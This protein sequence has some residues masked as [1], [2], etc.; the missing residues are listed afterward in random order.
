MKM[1]ALRK[2]AQFRNVYKF[3]IGWRN[4]LVIVKAVANDL[5]FSRYGFSVTKS[6]GKAVVRNKI[7]RR[8]REIM[9]M[10]PV[11]SGW[12][13]VVI[14]RPESVDTD[15][16]QLERSVKKLLLRADLLVDKNETVGNRVN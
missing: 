1:W 16:K 9:R 13:L 4:R 10:L 14:A 15:F 8:L 3:G 12:D 6:V 7:R 11:K 2:R 5:E